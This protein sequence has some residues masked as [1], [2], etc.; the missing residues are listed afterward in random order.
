MPRNVVSRYEDTKDVLR[1]KESSKREHF[2][3]LLGDAANYQLG[4]GPQKDVLRLYFLARNIL[5]EITDEM[6]VHKADVTNVIGAIYIESGAAYIHEVAELML[7]VLQNRRNRLD[8]RKKSDPEYEEDFICV[9]NALSN[10]SCCGI[11]LRKRDKG[12]DAVQGS[13]RIFERF[14]TE[15]FHTYVFS[16]GYAN[17]DREL[18][19]QENI[20][21]AERST[22]LQ[23]KAF[24]V[25]EVRSCIFESHWGN[26]LIQAGQA[27]KVYERHKAVLH[28]Q[29]SKLGLGTNDVARGLYLIA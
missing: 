4:R 12:N 5:E 24:G 21:Y 6:S 22:E 29:Q 14:C 1:D 17:L 15:D 20:T 9:S 11:G 8:S 7:R 25:T 27:Q 2:A 3:S 19:G 28:I 26:F 10:L 23:R 13:I 18:A 16:E